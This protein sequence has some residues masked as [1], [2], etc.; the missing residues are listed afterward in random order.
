MRLFMLW[1]LVCAALGY[2]GYVFT[3]AAPAPP[4]HPLGPGITIEQSPLPTRSR[5]AEPT[6]FNPS[7]TPKP[8]A[9]TGAN[10]SAPSTLP[11][12]SKSA[13]IK[14]LPPSDADDDDD[15]G[16]NDDDDDD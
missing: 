2:L 3:Q 9:G 4:P 8:P 13:P 7:G 10:S 12:P 6:E 11:I 1:A 14:P 5:P 16:G 15:H